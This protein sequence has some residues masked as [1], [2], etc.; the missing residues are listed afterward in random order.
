MRYALYIGRTL[1]G[2]L[3]FALVGGAYADD[4]GKTLTQKL[5]DADG[6]VALQKME[7]DLNKGAPPAAV[8]A[9]PTP[10]Q[11][12]AEADRSKPRTIALYGV[13]GRAAGG[14]LSL[15]S[16]VQ[17]GGETY[18]AKVGGKW[19][20]Y[21]ISGITESGTT[22]TKGK[23]RIFAPYE[24]DDAVNL[25]DQR[26]SGD[27]ST[28]G[29]PSSP[30]QPQGVSPTAPAGFTP[31]MPAQPSPLPTPATPVMPALAPAQQPGGMPAVAQR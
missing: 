22:L 28:A 6:R 23:A 29:R 19:R 21:T 14:A 5:I 7:Q 1:A 26:Q 20:G 13:D 16:Y 18:A 11:V 17:W 30:L 15:R 4:N 8:S 2:I 24:Q 10:A 3:G 9:A 12:K 25:I 27:A 31:M